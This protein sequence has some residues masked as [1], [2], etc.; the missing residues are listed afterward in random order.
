MIEGKPLLFE[1]QAAEKVYYADF[2]LTVVSPGGHSRPPNLAQ[3][4]IYSWRALDAIAAYSFPVSQS[5]I[6][7]SMKALGDH[8]EGKLADAMR[9]AWPIPKMYRPPR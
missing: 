5:E 2:L 4:A 8:S 1:I 7:A 3:N 9:T 6:T